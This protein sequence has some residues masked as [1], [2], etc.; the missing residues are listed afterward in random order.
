MAKCTICTKTTWRLPDD[1]WRLPDDWLR[2]AWWLLNDCLINAWWL[3]NDYLTTAWQ[4]E[5]Y[6]TTAKLTFCSLWQQD[7]K[8]YGVTCSSPWPKRILINIIQFLNYLY[9]EP[10]SHFLGQH[11]TILWQI[12]QIVAC[13]VNTVY[14]LER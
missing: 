14:I 3:P 9:N 8:A 5:D 13:P 12:E 10:L 11:L 6:F 4:L 7:K 2:T 1:A